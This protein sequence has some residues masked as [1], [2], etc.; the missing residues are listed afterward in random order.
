MKKYCLVVRSP[1]KD[2][3]AKFYFVAETILEV[4]E[5]LRNYCQI[6]PFEEEQTKTT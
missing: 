5:L 3:Q 6:Y 1:K 4:K 2:D